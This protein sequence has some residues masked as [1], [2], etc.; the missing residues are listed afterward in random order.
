MLR[1]W[2][3][4]TLIAA[5][6]GAC[7]TNPM[8][9]ATSNELKLSPPWTG[10]EH[11]DYT[12]MADQDGSPIGSG[13]IDVKPSSDA[14]TIEQ[15]Y[16][17]DKV[18]QHLV[19]R[20][21]PQSLKPL[22]GTQQVSGSPNDYSLAT[23]YQ[24]NELTIKATTSQGE[25][26]FTL[27][28]APD[29]IDNDSVLMV[30]RGVPLTDGYSASFHIVVATTALQVPTTLNVAARETVT[31]PAGTFNTYKVTLGFGSGPGQTA[32]YEVAAPH[33]M[34]QYDNG[35]DKFVLVKSS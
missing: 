32:W 15:H 26:D 28:V 17:F 21:D 27:E 8:P 30:L 12:V 1:K 13:A 3:A 10:T 35:Q 16:Q 2:F 4:I 23:K 19:V 5:L 24:N 29:A 33:R 34:I 11:F 25:K 22:G 6:A 20:I 7:G 9:V 31:V 18:A 14:T